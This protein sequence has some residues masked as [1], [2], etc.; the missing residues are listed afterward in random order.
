MWAGLPNSQGCPNHNVGFTGY[1]KISPFVKM[2]MPQ[3]ES[4]DPSDKWENKV[5]K[6]K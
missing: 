6:V 4:D 3:D 2:T 1:L 5:L